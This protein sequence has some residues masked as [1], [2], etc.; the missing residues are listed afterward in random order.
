MNGGRALGP[1]PFFILYMRKL[2][3]FLCAVLLVCSLAFGQT[4]PEMTF[5]ERIIDLGTLTYPRPDT[6]VV[7]RFKNAGNVPFAI[8]GVFPGCK[9]M[10]ATYSK[11][12][13]MPG[14]SSSF[15]VSYHFADYGPF[16]KTITITYSTGDNPEVKYMRVG[17]KGSAEK[18]K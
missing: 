10:K 2:Y 15:V 1:A 12:P 8:T 9:C 6:T 17:V 4:P 16:S 3:L 14:D 11:E 5:K 18:V 13:V 7:F